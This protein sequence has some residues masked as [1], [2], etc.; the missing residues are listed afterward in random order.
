MPN[1]LTSLTAVQKYDN[2]NMNYAEICQP[3]IIQC[4]FDTKE[5]FGYF[6]ARL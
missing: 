2:R 5:K 3:M 6:L 1:T 4:F